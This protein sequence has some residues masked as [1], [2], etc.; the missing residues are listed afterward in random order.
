MRS[1]SCDCRSSGIA[2]RRERPSGSFLSA[3]LAALPTAGLRS[4]GRF[5]TEAVVGFGLRVMTR[6]ARS[7]VDPLDEPQGRPTQGAPRKSAQ[8]YWRVGKVPNAIVPY[9]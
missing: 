8:F 7:A 4:S 3:F 5:L 1:L 9:V 2:G 6:G